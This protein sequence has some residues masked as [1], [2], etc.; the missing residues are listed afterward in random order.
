M[1]QKSNKRI[2]P[3]R[4]GVFSDE[5]KFTTSITAALSVKNCQ[6]I[7]VDNT[8][9][10]ATLANFHLDLCIIDLAD[11]A[12]SAHIFMRRIP[13]NLPV[14]AVVEDAGREFEFAEIFDV[15]VRPVDPVRLGENID[16][17]RKAS[18]PGDAPPLP[19]TDVELEQFSEFVSRHCGLHFDRRNRK[20]LERGII[21]RMSVVAATSVAA[22]FSYLERFQESRQELKKLASLLTIGETSFLRF[23]PHF[24]ALIEKVLPEL[25]KQQESTRRLRIWS[26]GCS[27]GEEVYS[28]ALTLL[29]NFPQLASWDI[30]IL[31]TDI[32]H[33]SLVSAREG[34]YRERALRNVAPELLEEWF[35]KAGTGWAVSDRLRLPTRFSFLNLQSET[36]PNPKNG[37]TECDLI[38]CRNVMI[39]FRPETV[40]AVVGRLRRAL[41]PGGYLFLGHAETLGGGFLDFVRCQHQGGIYYRA[42]AVDTVAETAQ[43]F[44]SFQDENIKQTSF[45]L[46]EKPDINGQLAMINPAGEEKISSINFVDKVNNK[47]SSQKIDHVRVP[48]KTLSGGLLEQGFLLADQG[49]LDEAFSLCQQVLYED[50][51]SP[52]GYLLRGL[53]RDQQG[54][55]Q[56]AAEDFQKTILLD[57]KSIMAHYH[58]AHVYRRLGRRVEALRSLQ[59]VVRLLTKIEGNQTIPDARDWTVS[60]LLE[61]CGAELKQLEKRSTH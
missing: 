6:I 45:I 52:R 27:T 55:S 47:T 61:R 35:V 48:Q 17:L 26:A 36:Y 10:P 14:I 12:F 38:F 28:L 60:G 29:R 53:I 40:R 51:L 49:R 25:I 59:T 44:Q 4:V 32:S 56:A 16:Y 41:R 18:R 54:L 13:N 34:V 3:L 43:T 21:R 37:T 30:T 20:N 11:P 50:D 33:K 1:P 7:P 15:M 19:P 23:D 9:P 42:G 2:S 24:S 5:A 58:L 39:Y 8:L 46:F 22:Y 31:G 57:I